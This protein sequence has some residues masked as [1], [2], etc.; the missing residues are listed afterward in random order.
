[1]PVLTSHVDPAARPTAPTAPPSSPCSTSWAS[2]WSWPSPA[3]ASATS[4]GTATG[5]GCWPGSGSS[6]CVDPDSPFLELSTLAAWGTGFTVG[7]SVVTGIGVVSGVEC[8]IIAH[9]PTV[10]GGAINPYSLRKSL[11]A[12]EI[13]RRQPAA[14][15]QPGRVGRRGPADPG[16]PVRPG[17][18][19]LPRPHRA[20]RAGHPDGRAG[21]RQLDRGRRVR[22]RHVRLRGAGG[23]AGQGVPRRPAA[24]EDGHRRGVRRRDARRRRDALPGLRAVRLL[25][26]RRARRDPDRPRHHGPD[27]LAQA[28]PAAG[29]GR[30]SRGTTRTRSS[31]SC[32]PT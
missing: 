31:A 2:S 18:P 15:D 10:R 30:P 27:Q 20:V 25:R 11:R 12:A 22:A 29:A 3:A 5:A 16:R 32:P 21:V 9:D 6:C 26:R 24:G 14:G 13:A 4:S 23:R 28:R 7:A 8:V 17:R 19:D 1:M